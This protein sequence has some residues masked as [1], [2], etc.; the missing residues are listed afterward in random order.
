MADVVDSHIFCKEC[1]ESSGLTGVA[2][3]HRQCPHCKT[4]LPN[5]DDAAETNLQPSEDYKSSV[6]SGFD[7][8]TIMECASR[9]LSWWNYQILF[10]TYVV[11]L[12]TTMF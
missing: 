7:P 10:E 3:K 1:A 12:A 11:S 4:P 5:V 8:T 2:L 9:A 6:L